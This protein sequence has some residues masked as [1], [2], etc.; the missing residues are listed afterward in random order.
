VR[1]RTGF[2]PV[3]MRLAVFTGGYYRR[4]TK[5]NH[6]MPSTITIRSEDT[7]TAHAYEK[8][9]FTI[10][11]ERNLHKREFPNLDEVVPKVAR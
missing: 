2:V 5:G 1:V 4:K 8:D 10:R 11:A 9:G 3:A 6:P 7:D